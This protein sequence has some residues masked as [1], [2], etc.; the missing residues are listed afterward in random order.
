MTRTTLFVLSLSFLAACGYSED[1]YGEDLSAAICDNLATCESDIVTAYTD[2]GMDE[3]TAQS[4]YDTTYTATCETEVEDN[5]DNG[6]DNCDFD[7]AAAKDCVA[8]VEE[9]GCDFWSTG[10]G[11]P[12]VCA[13]V[14]G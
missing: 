6:D 7:S 1:T 5:G 3:A 12:A 11:Y 14:C 9:M 4:T 13:T 2:L 10:T 8:E